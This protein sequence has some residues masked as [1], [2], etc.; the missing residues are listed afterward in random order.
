MSLKT[1]S[2]F[3]DTER[4]IVTLAALIALFTMLHSFHILENRVLPTF[5]PSHI[6]DARF[7]VEHEV[8]EHCSNLT[9]MRQRLERAEYLTDM[10]KVALRNEREALRVKMKELGD[11]KPVGKKTHRHYKLVVTTDPNII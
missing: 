11:E 10:A 8:K 9:A 5:D 6:L 2:I 1:H 3:L 7:L 4:G